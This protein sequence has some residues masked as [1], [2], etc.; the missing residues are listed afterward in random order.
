MHRLTEQSDRPIDRGTFDSS[1][2]GLGGG[3]KLFNESSIINVC[4]HVKKHALYVEY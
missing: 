2:V 3:V 4:G 1:L